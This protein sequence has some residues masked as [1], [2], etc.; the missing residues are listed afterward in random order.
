[1]LKRVCVGMNIKRTNLIIAVSTL[2]NI[3]TSHQWFKDIFLA[4]VRETSVNRS[5]AKPAATSRTITHERVSH[6]H[7]VFFNPA[8]LISAII[9][10]DDSNGNVELN[11]FY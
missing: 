1:M 3:F 11:V 7:T 10:I 6:L 9:D 8:P 5:D 4:T 2:N